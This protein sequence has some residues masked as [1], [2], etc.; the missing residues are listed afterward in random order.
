MITTSTD[1][2]RRDGD[3]DDDDVDDDEDEDDEK[4]GVPRRAYQ[5]PKP[6]PYSG[7][8]MAPSLPYSSPEQS[9][10]RCGMPSS[11]RFQARSNLDGLRLHV[12]C[13]DLVA[14]EFARTQDSQ[15][16]PLATYPARAGP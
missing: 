11:A 1:H 12:A 10:S 4:R 6:R 14:P 13:R 8:A 9:K 16:H 7:G 2:I 5:V 3:D 15:F